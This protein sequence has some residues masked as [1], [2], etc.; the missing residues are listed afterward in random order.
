MKFNKL[1]DAFARRWSKKLRAIRYLGGKCSGC[2]NDNVFVLNFHHVS[3]KDE[4][5]SRIFSSDGKWKR[6]EKEI[7]KC[8]LLCRN[9]HIEEHHPKS[10]KA[11]KELLKLL[12]IS[13]CSECGCKPKST[14][15][16]EFH[17]EGVKDFS[18]YQAFNGT[19]KMVMP[20]DKVVAETKKCKVLCSNCH[21]IEHSAISKFKSL[22]KLIDIKVV[23]HRG[24]NYVDKEKIL[25]LFI[26]GM[27]GSQIARKL[28]YGTTT[29][30]R[31]LSTVIRTKMGNKKFYEK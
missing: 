15:V 21:A 17:H 23:D 6:V 3:G 28:G 27:Y 18:I 20:L 9:C 22:K 30:S 26:G 25:R 4:L 13:R 10:N 1:D 16:M 24:I 7:K 11:K 31:V 5:V 19:D 14:A 2:G 8:I 29:V 12:K